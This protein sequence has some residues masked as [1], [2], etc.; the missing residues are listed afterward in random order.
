MRSNSEAQ[1]IVRN[2][3]DYKEMHNGENSPLW[4]EDFNDLCYHSKHNRK[5]KELTKIGVFE[6]EYCPICD[7]PKGK[8]RI[9]LMNIN[10]QYENNILD[11]YYM[12]KKCHEG[13]NHYLVG[14]WKGKIKPIHNLI[15]NLLQLKTREEREQLLKK[16][17]LKCKNLIKLN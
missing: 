15:E 9:D 17:I 6:P 2:R 3:P 10:H 7:K 11:Y 1:K 12:C 14:L 13:I 4:K 16:V 8:R 5:R